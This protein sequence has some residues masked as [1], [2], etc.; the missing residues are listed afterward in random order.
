MSV[1][2]NA[3]LALLTAFVATAAFAGEQVLV[4]DP[5][6]SKVSFILE[7]TGHDVEGKLALRSGRI[8]FDP[9]TGTASG[10]IAVD[11]KSAETGNGSRDK[12]M[13]EKVLED[14]T[15]PLAVFR[16]EHLRGTVAPSGPS[17]VT[18]DGTLSFHGADH[19]MSLPAQ[20]DIKN[21][22][23]TAETR[24]PIPFIEWGLHDP[25]IAFLRVAK[26]VSVKVVAQGALE[27]AAE[28]AGRK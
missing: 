23:L 6:T 20:V 7:A 10:E 25:S 15:Y 24:F 28:E 27:G 16:A 5:A 1:S 14:S 8:A 12:T 4:L 19:K 21:G 11:L 17:Q 3:V 22:R 2:R 26:V 18:L 9:E 13:H